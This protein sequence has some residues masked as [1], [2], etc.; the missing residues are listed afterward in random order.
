LKSKNLSNE[1]LMKFYILLI[2]LSL[3][4]WI[5]GFIAQ[6]LADI[7]P[8]N[9]PVS[10]IMFICPL[11]AVLILTPK[12]DRH[13]II[14]KLLRRIFDYKKI[15]KRW[16]LIIFCLM[17]CV[18]VVSYFIMILAGLQ[19]PEPVLPLAAIPIF[20]VVFFFCAACEEIG[21]IGYV[22]D[23]MERRWDALKM[24]AVI[25]VIWGVWHSI[26]YFQSNHDL[27]WIFWQ[28]LTSVFNRILI[29]WIYNNNGKSMFSGISYHAMIN[30][31]VFLFPNYGSHYNPAIT[32][33]LLGIVSV[34]VVR[35]W[36]SKTLTSEK[37]P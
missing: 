26:P 8:I 11:I 23:R 37:N 7:L 3:P 15:K 21:W 14:G 30:V 25:G 6:D 22:G 29:V 33:V 13:N 32:A 2:V 35:I 34:I 19:L 36:G 20:V 9:L 28:I 18:M 5:L 16:Y 24:G 1:S 17:P 31:S 4:L 27:V 12:E 10:A